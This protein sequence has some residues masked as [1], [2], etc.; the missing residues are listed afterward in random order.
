MDTEYVVVELKYCEG[1][2]GLYLRLPGQT[3]PYCPQCRE[4]F[5]RI[6]LP[7]ARREA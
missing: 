1:C 5:A 3:G 4:K 6:A 2:G 7:P